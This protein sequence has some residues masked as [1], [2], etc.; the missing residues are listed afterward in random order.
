M[1]D[2]LLF[3]ASCGLR[4]TAVRVYS[5]DKVI[6]RSKFNFKAGMSAV[7]YTHMRFKINIVMNYLVGENALKH[8]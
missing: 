3:I 6:R 2:T 4:K 5:N 8:N 1:A 7:H